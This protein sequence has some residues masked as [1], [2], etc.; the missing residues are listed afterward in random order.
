MKMVAD[1]QSELP[2][3][4]LRAL[5]SYWVEQYGVV[6][7]E[8]SA[9]AEPSVV[10]RGQELNEESCVLCHD[11]SRSAFVSF[12]VARSLGPVAIGLDQAGAAPV[13]WW[14]HV[15]AVLAG[16]AYLVFGKMFHIIGT[17]VS[18]MI[19]DASR[20]EQDPAAALTRQVIELDGCGHGGD[21]H[22][23]CPVF[24]RRQERIG[25]TSAYEPM[26]H[27]LEQKSAAD[28]GSRKVSG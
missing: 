1:Y 4:D 19:A 22:E 12:A 8:G 26:L 3:E 13:L 20:G 25:D 15:L 9:T 10:A 18:L 6:A 11:D 7:P 27:Y 21:C 14:I 5:R 28:L 23:N 16:L 17:P 2:E 24:L